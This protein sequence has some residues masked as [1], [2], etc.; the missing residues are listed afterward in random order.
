MNA[1]AS[2]RKIALG[3]VSLFVVTQILAATPE[4]DPTATPASVSAPNSIDSGFS[5]SGTLTEGLATLCRGGGLNIRFGVG[6]DNGVEGTYGSYS[7]TGVSGGESVK[8]IFDI[9]SGFNCGNF[10]SGNL[11][12]SGFSSN[13]G[14]MWL[15][16][17]DCHGVT[18]TQGSSSYSYNGG[19]AWWSWTS[20]FG[21]SGN[22][23][24][25]SCTINHN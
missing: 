8:G 24:Q 2:I 14:S 4:V 6:F 16:S 15:T 19:T 11:V 25:V 3:Q 13:P 17:I 18:L 7:P 9:S 10:V 1:C 5:D 23:A 20:R 22:G 12:I 21:F